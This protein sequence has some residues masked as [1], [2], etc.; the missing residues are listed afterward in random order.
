MSSN[1]VTDIVKLAEHKQKCNVA[2]ADI[3]QSA[4]HKQ[5]YKVAEADIVKSAEH[6]Q[7]SKLAEADITSNTSL[8]LFR[9]RSGPMHT[10]RRHDVFVRN[11]SL[12]RQFGIIADD[13]LDVSK[14]APRLFKSIPLN[15]IE[16]DELLFI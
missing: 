2:E 5:K 9:P 6:K 15:N 14:L 11:G 13:S 10:Q 16:T 4:E 7:K 12:T 1:T 8:L 3:L